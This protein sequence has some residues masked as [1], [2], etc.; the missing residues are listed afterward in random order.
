MRWLLAFFFLLL[1]VPPEFI[2]DLE[3]VKYF[4][5]V[6]RGFATLQPSDLAL[7]LVAIPLFRW[8]PGTGS[9]FRRHR[10]LAISWLLF[11]SWAMLLTIWTVLWGQV[12]ESVAWL[13]LAKL[14]KFA[15]YCLLAVAAYHSIASPRDLRF[16]V[17]VFVF[18]LSA[19]SVVILVRAPAT[20]WDPAGVVSRGL[21]KAELPY[22]GNPVAVSLAVGLCFLLAALDAGPRNYATSALLAA[23]LLATTGRAGYAAALFGVSYFLLAK[24]RFRL[25]IPVAILAVLAFTMLML[26]AVA[27]AVGDLFARNPGAEADLFG[28]STNGRMDVYRFFFDEIFAQKLWYGAGFGIWGEGS[29]LPDWTMHNFF[30]QMCAE[31]GLPGFALCLSTILLLFREFRTTATGH[32]LGSRYSLAAAGATIAIVVASLTETYLYGGTALA[33]YSFV[34][35]IALAARRLDAQGSRLASAPRPPTGGAP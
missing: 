1:A 18:T 31:L 17:S 32:S 34:V 35:G 19:I 2:T 10:R 3:F 7:P 8:L 12:P 30:L 22:L 27:D 28:I 11:V 24:R 21:L 9:F 26:P 15:A 16:F 5:E 23:A 4:A 33:V 6:K 20:L 14:L 29:G 25:A 13:G